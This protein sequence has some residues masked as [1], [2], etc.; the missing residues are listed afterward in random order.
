MNLN[1]RGHYLEKLSLANVVNRD[2]I[3][4]ILGSKDVK[5]IKGNMIG[6]IRREFFDLSGFDEELLTE[7]FN[8]EFVEKVKSSI[9]KIISPLDYF[10]HSNSSSWFFPN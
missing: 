2:D 10:G 5:A 6:N 7:V 9:E 1:L 3:L 8:Y 4:K